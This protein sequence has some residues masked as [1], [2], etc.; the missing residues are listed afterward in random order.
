[1]SYSRKN[2]K[3][4]SPNLCTQEPNNVDNITP[5]LVVD[6]SNVGGVICSLS[7]GHRSVFEAY[8]QQYWKAVR[9]H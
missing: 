6:M 2:I 4:H 5:W 9:V 1:M 7:G 3:S 8:V